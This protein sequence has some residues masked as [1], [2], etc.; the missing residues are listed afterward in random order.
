MGHG[1]EASVNMSCCSNVVAHLKDVIL[2]RKVL[3]LTINLLAHI[4]KI[5]KISHTLYTA[6][7]RKVTDL[8][9]TFCW[10]SVTQ[11][12]I[13]I[14]Q[15]PISPWRRTALSNCSSSYVLYMFYII[16]AETLRKYTQMNSFSFLLLWFNIK[17][18]I[19]IEQECLLVFTTANT[20]IP[21]KWSV[22]HR[23]E[24]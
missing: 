22:V 10:W 7:T 21:V 14:G 16:F 11:S 4:S 15:W 19:W 6:V 24:R 20:V 23:E 17:K 8:D 13:W 1:P 9:A 12:G 5:T 18:C 2:S 3:F